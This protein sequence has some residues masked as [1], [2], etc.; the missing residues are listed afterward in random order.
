MKTKIIQQ[1]T[2]EHKLPF[3]TVE[4]I[5]RRQDPL[6]TAAGAHIPGQGDIELFVDHKNKVVYKVGTADRLTSYLVDYSVTVLAHNSGLN[7]A[8][9]LAKPSQYGDYVV[10]ATSYMQ[11]DPNGSP[12]PRTAG[13]A[14]ARLHSIQAK[15]IRTAIS[16]LGEL[17]AFVLNNCTLSPKERRAIETRCLDCIDLVTSDMSSKTTLVHGDLHLGNILPTAADPTL[18]DFEAAGS[19]SPLWDL[20]VLVQSSSRFGLDIAW[21][22]NFLESWQTES[23]QVINPKLLKAYVDWRLWYGVLSMLKRDHLD[24]GDAKELQVRRKWLN[25]PSDQSKWT[26]C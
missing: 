14:L 24:I 22:N 5:I 16:E 8:K 19:G 7:V 15:G 25:D 11:H 10:Y 2:L 17:A 1:Y 3:N 9:P 26:R 13:R 12:S 23:G 18:I 6:D 4:P 21:V 20:A